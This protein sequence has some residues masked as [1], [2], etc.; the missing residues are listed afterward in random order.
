MSVHSTDKEVEKAS[1]DS[2]SE[3]NLYSFHEQRAGR[4]VIDPE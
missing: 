4:L 2:G 1:D 3:I